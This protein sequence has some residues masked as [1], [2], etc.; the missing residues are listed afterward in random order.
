MVKKGKVSW[1][2]YNL[3]DDMGETSDLVREQAE[4]AAGMK[5]ALT[6]WQQSVIDSLNGK[7]Y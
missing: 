3:N 6:T 2:L 1:E 4:R 7:D 5:K